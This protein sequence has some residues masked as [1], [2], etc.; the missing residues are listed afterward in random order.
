MAMVYDPYKCY[1]KKLSYSYYTTTQFDLK[2]FDY[3][4]ESMV[5][6][7]EKVETR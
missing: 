6:I 1:M 5:E 4:D 3:Q 7:I 2:S